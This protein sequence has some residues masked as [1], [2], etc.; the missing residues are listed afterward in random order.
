VLRRITIECPQCGL[1]CRLHLGTTAPVV[2]VR[3]PSC[4]TS[5]MGWRDSAV[6]LAE[7]DMKRIRDGDGDAV[8]MHLLS[9]RRRTAG[10]GGAVSPAARPRGGRGGLPG[11]YRDMSGRR[12]VTHDDVLDLHMMLE[13]CADAAAFIG[14]LRGRGAGGRAGEGV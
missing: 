2:V 6:V 5:L 10:R 14:L 3:C 1:V 4:S 7:E 8:I 11:G 12:V 13:G 9:E